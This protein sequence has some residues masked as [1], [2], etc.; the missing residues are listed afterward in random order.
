MVTGRGHG[1][2]PLSTSQSAPKAHQETP[3]GSSPGRWYHGL[4]IEMEIS[5]G[6]PGLSTSPALCYM[7][8][9]TNASSICLYDSFSVWPT[10]FLHVSYDPI[11]I[12]MYLYIYIN[13]YNWLY[14]ICISVCHSFVLTL[15]LY[16]SLL[17][18]V[19]PL[20]RCGWP[21]LVASSVTKL[22]PSLWGTVL[23]GKWQA[24]HCWDTDISSS[25]KAMCANSQV[26]SPM[27]SSSAISISRICVKTNQQL[28]V[29]I[30]IFWGPWHQ[31]NLRQ[32][33]WDGRSVVVQ[34]A[35]WL[36]SLPG[37]IF[38]CPGPPQYPVHPLAPLLFPPPM[39]R[40]L[41]LWNHR[42]CVCVLFYIIISFS[43]SCFSSV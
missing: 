36:D 2:S 25:I 31:Q 29:A 23:N 41:P 33:P 30:F 8:Q 24:M 32:P 5:A 12:P 10:M 38:S 11:S 21:W 26:G 42:L 37:R 9:A 14:V 4:S 22:V 18:P 20:L 17:W 27:H 39:D 6:H 7:P 15:I 19:P 13:L 43:R 35:K 34:P 1:L 40:L 28:L 3:I 16:P